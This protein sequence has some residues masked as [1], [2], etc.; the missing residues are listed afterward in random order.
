MTTELS[1][2]K[3]IDDGQVKPPS[4][5]GG[6]EP[7]TSSTPG[8][9]P[10]SESLPNDTSMDLKP[11]LQIWKGVYEDIQTRGTT[12]KYPIGLKTI[13]DVIWGLHKRELLTLGARTSHGK[14]ALALNMA[15]ALADRGQRVV[16]FSLEMSKEQ[17]VE[18][19]LANFCHI[20]NRWLRHGLAKSQVEG[21]KD[22]F[23]GL[24]EG[25]K[26]LIDDQYGYSFESVVKICD[27]VRPDFVF[28]DYIQ[29]VSSKGFRSKL[30]AIEE[31]VRKFKQ[32]SNE[33]NFGA[34]LVSQINRD[35][36]GKMTMANLKGA[37][38]L[39][40]HSDTV[41]LL[42]WDWNANEYEVRVDKQRHGEVKTVHIGFQPE[43]FK[44]SDLQVAGNGR[45]YGEK[46]L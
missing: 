12:P 18:R 2:P 39:E 28:L 17:L 6:S 27:I 5:S 32:L 38:V 23:E 9:V 24:I 22:T 42:Q 11:L 45:R 26:L 40:E 41:I 8:S 3:T 15:A 14:S 10:R 4:L 33:M 16:Y 25:L 44:F 7:V 43:F 31:Y 36:E 34:I 35:G 19:L 20:D 13:D 37:G 21:T 30:D 1:S 46:D 29:M